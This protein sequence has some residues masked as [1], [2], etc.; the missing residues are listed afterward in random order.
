M[1]VESFQLD[2]AERRLDMVVDVLRVVQHRHRLHAA[3]IL[4]EPD[5][6]PFADGH[7]Q[8]LLVC[9]AVKLYSRGLH[10]FSHLFLGFAREGPLNLLASAGIVARRDAGLPICVSS[11]LACDGLLSNRARPLRGAGI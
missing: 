6:E 4:R 5:I 3:Q 8:R 2:R 11:T 10:L 1:S 7:F 9:S